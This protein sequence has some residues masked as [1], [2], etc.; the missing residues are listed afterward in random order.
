MRTQSRKKKIST[1]VKMLTVW[2]ELN[3]GTGVSDEILAY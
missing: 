1:L 3:N 2:R